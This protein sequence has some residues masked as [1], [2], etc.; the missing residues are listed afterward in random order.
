MT[1]A[2]PSDGPEQEIFLRALREYSEQCEPPELTLGCPFRRLDPTIGPW[3]L[4]ECMDLLAEHNAPPAIAERTTVGDLSISRGR[5]PRSRRGLGAS[6]RA[7]DARELYLSDEAEPVAKRRTGS[8][9]YALSQFLSAP[10]TVG[11][12]L[13]AAEV[14]DPQDHMNELARRGYDVEL[15]IREGLGH[16]V[17]IAILWSVI[18]PRVMRLEGDG[19]AEAIFDPVVEPWDALFAVPEAGDPVY[20]V[21]RYGPAVETWV[22]TAPLD[23]VLAWKAPGTGRFSPVGVARPPMGPHRWLVDRHLRTYLADWDTESLKLEYQYQVGRHM[24]PCPAAEMAS[25]KIDE[26][27]LTRVLADRLVLAG[28]STYTDLHRFTPIAVDLLRDGK[29]ANAAAIFSA[30]VD[31]EPS[32]SEAQNNLGFCLLPDDPQ[33]ALFSLQKAADL[34]DGPLALSA[35][36]VGNRILAFAMLGRLTPALELAERFHSEIGDGSSGGWMWDPGLL[37]GKDPVLLEVPR[38]EE[39]VLGLAAEVARVSG[40][41]TLIELWEE[42]TTTPPQGC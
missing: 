17:A 27:E 1:S 8:L 34:V 37:T 29:R 13:D 35:A 32:H 23:E 41:P 15:L 31:A 9:L 19:D 38:I 7:F 16:E 4:D 26:H 42:R 22:R 10:R 11:L 20:P 25:R 24:P 39:Y 6:S 40:E 18:I 30:I 36:N 33:R 3:C 5:R 14:L 28:R 21:L 2:M 12:K